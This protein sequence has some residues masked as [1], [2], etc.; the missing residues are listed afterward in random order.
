MPTPPKE[1]Q[2]L[3]AELA[4]LRDRIMVYRDELAGN[5]APD[6][7]RRGFLEWQIRRAPNRGSL[8]QSWPAGPILP[9][10]SFAHTNKTAF[11]SSAGRAPL[12]PKPGARINSTA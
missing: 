11:R 7:T 3:E 2:S 12:R 6:E 10:S 1:R 5:P 9:K 4:E 8:V